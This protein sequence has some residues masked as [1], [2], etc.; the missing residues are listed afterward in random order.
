MKN[1]IEDNLRAEIAFWRSLIDDWEDT[2]SNP[3]HSRIGYALALAE[4]KL[5]QLAS[6][7]AKTKLH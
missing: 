1:T 6:A 3:V 2:Q 7:N 4:Y 5:Q